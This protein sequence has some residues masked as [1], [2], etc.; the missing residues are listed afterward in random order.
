MPKLQQKKKAV[1][2]DERKE[3][4]CAVLT[5][6]RV[7]SY[8]PQYHKRAGIQQTAA[9]HVQQPSSGAAALAAEQL[10][11]ADNNSYS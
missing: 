3:V 2:E 9:A 8:S 6:A 4:E 10:S 7:Q 1:D 5:M 11:L